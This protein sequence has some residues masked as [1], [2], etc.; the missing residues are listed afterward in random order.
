MLDD[1]HQLP[2]VH[3]GTKGTFPHAVAAE[4]TL[5]VVNLLLAVLVLGDGPNRAGFLAGNGNLDDGVVGTV[6]HT[7][8]TVD[9]GILVDV[10][11]SLLDFDAV[12]DA[13]GDAGTGKAGL[14]GVGDHVM[15][16]DA[17]IAGL[18]QDGEHGPGGLFPLQG[19]LSEFR[20]L[21]F[22]VVVLHTVAQ[23]GHHPHPQN[24]TVVVDA[25][26]N[27]LLSQR[28]HLARDV[29][30]SLLQLS[31]QLE[32]CNADQNLSLEMGRLVVY[33]QHN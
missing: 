23:A 15:G 32:L 11:T 3:H 10:G 21:L 18:V 12:L 8:A 31:F 19:L 17:G 26:P 7:K 2:L 22:V 14:A 30:H 20:Q 25:A 16:L 6:L 28:C 9:A 27:R 33:V 29:M 4:N 1:I 13:V 5:V 24:L